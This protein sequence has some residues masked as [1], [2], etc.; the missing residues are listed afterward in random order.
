MEN[1]IIGITT[2]RV[3]LSNK[4]PLI[5]SPETYI[6]SILNAGGIPILLPIPL[7]GNRLA[8][9]VKGLDGILFTGGGD[10][11]PDIYR[12]ENHP[13]VYDVQKDR[14]TFEISLVDHALF[15]R[16]PFFGICRGIQIINVATGGTLYTDINSKVAKA[17]PHNSFAEHPADFRAHPVRVIAGTKLASIVKTD[18]LEVN[19]MH[20]Q[21]IDQPSSTLTVSAVAPDGIVE[22]VEIKDHPFGMGVQWHPEALGKDVP[23]QLLFKAF[24]QAAALFRSNNS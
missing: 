13:S 19:S 17:L 5:G 11:D 8:D 3:S 16:M 18:R 1:P 15:R 7:S 6:N 24:I 10:I 4:M 9:V 2:R 22:A 20:H 12:G 21:G 23:S 14:D